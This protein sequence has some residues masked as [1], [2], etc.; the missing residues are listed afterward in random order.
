MR[1]QHLKKVLQICLSTDVTTLG[2]TEMS[3]SQELS[4]CLV[5]LE[6]YR[7]KLTQITH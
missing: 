3:Q 1:N 7:E 5:C 2:Q 4:K 6:F